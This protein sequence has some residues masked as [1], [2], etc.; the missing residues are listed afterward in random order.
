M[1]SHASQFR[2]VALRPGPAAGVTGE[3]VHG[4]S[5]IRLHVPSPGERNR[6]P[7]RVLRVGKFMLGGDEPRLALPLIDIGLTRTCITFPPGTRLMKGELFDI[8]RPVRM[9]ADGAFP[10]GG[11]RKVVALVKIVGMENEVRA[12][13]DILGGSLRKGVWAERFDDRRIAGRLYGF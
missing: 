6:R 1:E 5:T 8:V 12:R 7:S 2:L 3:R 13:V 9:R 4:R 11:L 10:S